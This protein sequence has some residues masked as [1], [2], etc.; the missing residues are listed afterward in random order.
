M[1]CTVCAVHF[2]YVCGERWAGHASYYSCSRGPDRDTN[3]D[4]QWLTDCQVAY[5]R[6]ERS[7][8]DLIRAAATQARLCAIVGLDVR[9]LPRC[10]RERLRSVT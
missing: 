5:A 6:H 8:A 10:A 2:C 4:A 3:L 9:W 7:D 1:V